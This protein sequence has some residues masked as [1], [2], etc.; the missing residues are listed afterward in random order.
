MDG[1]LQGQL[2]G[3]QTKETILAPMS[4]DSFIYVSTIFF[5]TIFLIISLAVIVF[6]SVQYYRKNEEW[7]QFEQKMW[8]CRLTEEEE[9]CLREK[10]R[11]LNY[12]DP[13]IILKSE[14]HFDNFCKRVLSKQDHNE[15][16]IF[17]VIREKIFEPG[18]YFALPESKNDM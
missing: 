14:I 3:F 5:G 9:T 18:R 16:K 6:K 17:H 15:E 8:H 2:H 13:V 10:L 1:I 7:R 12:S 11:T 4:W